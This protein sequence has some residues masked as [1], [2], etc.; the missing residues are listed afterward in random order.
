[1]LTLCQGHYFSYIVR[2]HLDNVVDIVFGKEELKR[3]FSKSMKREME[4][5]GREDW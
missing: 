4:I 5:F 3:P 1:M 2:F